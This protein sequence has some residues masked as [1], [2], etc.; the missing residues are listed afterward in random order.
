[1]CL[2]LWLDATYTMAALEAKL[3]SY[4]SNPAAAS[5]PLDI[6]TVPKISKEQARQDAIRQSSLRVN[7]VEAHSGVYRGAKPN[8][9]S[10][11]DRTVTNPARCGR[12]CYSCYSGGRPAIRLLSAVG[13]DRRVQGLWRCSEEQQEGY[14]TY[15]TRDR[16]RCYCSQAHLQRTYCLP[17]M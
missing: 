11:R 1:M 5:E 14:R 16:I 13:R 8:Q 10:G 12:L 6:S 2:I 15:R 3:A 7:C 4:V 9:R 17:S